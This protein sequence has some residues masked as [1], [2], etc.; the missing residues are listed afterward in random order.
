MVTGPPVSSTTIVRGFAAA[1]AL[2]SRSWLSGSERLGRSRP[3]LAGWLTKTMATLEVLARAA[4]ATGFVPALYSTRAFGAFARIA[5]S[6]EE[7][8]QTGP[9]PK[10]PNPRRGPPGAGG[11]G[12]TAFPPGGS[13]WAE[14]PPERTPTSAC[15]PITAIDL[16]L[17]V[18]SGN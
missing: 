10:P 11:G 12:G 8:N 15:E 14:P 17:A 18:F 5:F 6:G 9:R 2:T 3:S 4:A 1:T 7:G 16:R 13:T